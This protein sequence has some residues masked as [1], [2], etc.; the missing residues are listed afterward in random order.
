MVI[1]GMIVAGTGDVEMVVAGMIVAGTRDVVM[2]VSAMIVVG[3][4]YV[5]IMVAAERVGRSPNQTLKI[6]GMVSCANCV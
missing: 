6:L 5:E 2:V 4:G 1:A 3:T